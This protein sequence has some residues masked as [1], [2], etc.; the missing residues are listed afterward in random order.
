MYILISWMM[1]VK[2]QPD[3]LKKSKYFQIA[4]NFAEPIEKLIPK[5]TLDAIKEKLPKSV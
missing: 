1:P 2:S 4:G 5:D 3:L